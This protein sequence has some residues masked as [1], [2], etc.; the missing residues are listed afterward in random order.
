MP[1]NPSL[2]VAR[3]S[4]IVLNLVYHALEFAVILETKRFYHFCACVHML[5]KMPGLAALSELKTDPRSQQVL[6]M[7]GIGKQWY[8]LYFSYDDSE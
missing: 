2:S 4:C 6:S 1:R 8:A 7:T 3:C 5:M